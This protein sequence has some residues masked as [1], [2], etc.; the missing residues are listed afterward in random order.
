MKKTIT[1]F[2]WLCCCFAFAQSYVPSPENMK[3]RKDFA[4]AKFGI[5]LHWGLYSMFGQGEWYMTNE[6]IN[7]HE[8]AKVAQAF[9]PHNFNA[10][11]WITAIK[12]SGAR[13]VYDKTP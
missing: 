8:Y 11:Q 2:V 7:C 9:Y 10:H 1:A 13:Y 6:N 5:F 3:A 12:K 4:D